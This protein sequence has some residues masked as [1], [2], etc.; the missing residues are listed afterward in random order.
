MKVDSSILV[1]NPHD[2][3]A[4]AR[5]LEELG[6]DGGFTFEGRHDPFLPLSIAAEH[7]ESLT[8]ATAVAIAFARNP[9]LLANLGYD[10]QLQSGGR[11]IL[12]LG[13]QIRP[14]IER[15]FSAVWSRPADRMREMVLAIR[16]I[17]R[18]WH[19][20][21]KLDFRGDFYTHTLMTPVFNP[22]PNPHGLPPIFVAGIGPKMTA[23]VGEVADGFFVHPFHTPKFIEE[24][25]LPA[26]ERGFAAS[27]RTRDDFTI[28]CQI[29][30]ASGESEEEFENAKN[31]ARAQLS[32]YG[33]T[34]AYRGVLD[35]HGW[36]DLHLE[37][38]RLSKTG[39]WLQMAALI[40]DEVLE[41]IAVVGEPHEIAG[42]LLDRCGSFAD[43]LSLVAVY[44][45]DAGRWLDVVRAIQGAE[46]T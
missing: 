30:I 32:F 4:V 14:H 12:G 1:S 16:A 23:A 33:S 37:L 11:F 26:L 6:Y 43:R 42:K 9:M 5:G 35:C 27:G 45:P 40:D 28:S 2:A 36:G 15:R 17:W 13:S 3:G 21:A 31:V 39:G 44:A 8:L 22:G 34:P 25:T 19:D 29:I 38:N 10:L 18:S 24:V 20:D 7:T 46:R 41:T